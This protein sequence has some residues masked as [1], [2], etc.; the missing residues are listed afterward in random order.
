MG[1]STG[2]SVDLAAL[3]G[4]L[5][6]LRRD[7]DKALSPSTRDTAHEL[8]DTARFGGACASGEVI[9]S[10]TDV[11][12]AASIA[13]YN[14]GVHVDN[15]YAIA[16]ALG[17]AVT[18]Y[19]AVDAVA[20]ETFGAHAH[21]H[22][23]A[24]ALAGSSSAGGP[25]GL[26]PVF[27]GPLPAPKIP[28][29][30]LQPTP[31]AL[32]WKSFDTPRMWTMVAGEASAEA[33]AQMHAFRRLSDLLN[34]QHR[35]MLALRE[36]LVTAW[37]PRGAG[38]EM[39]AVW[40]KHATALASDSMCAYLT[41]K[42]MEGILQTLND[43]QI[44][45]SRLNDRWRHITTD[46]VPEGWDHA[47]EETNKKARVVMIEAEKAVADYRK[48]VAVPDRAERIIHADEGVIVDGGGRNGD[49]RQTN[50]DD[51]TTSSSA[52]GK[53]RDETQVPRKGGRVVVPSLPGTSPV[54]DSPELAGGPQPVRVSPSTPP[55]LLPIPPRVSDV[56]PGGG[57]YILPGSWSGGGRVLPMPYS[58]SAN[59]ANAY[60]RQVGPGVGSPGMFGMPGVPGAAAGARETSNRQRMATEQWEVAKGVPP[61][62]EPPKSTAEDPSEDAPT[63]EELADYE[64]WYERVSAPWRLP[65]EPEG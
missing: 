6:E 23:N 65:P 14:V 56:A 55:S 60:G 43:A 40:D 29:Q 61:V 32:R 51:G 24:G 2:I 44:K 28:I 39:L 59:S 20:G 1:V 19:A 47:A 9:A 48:G 63:D 12:Y 18:G 7:V 5:S 58:S 64:K 35:R 45:M 15:A 21:A 11:S 50:G 53:G 42:A 62:I 13:A 4:L 37:T 36:R 26:T 46:F 25:D 17:F 52:E 41:A 49:G 33:W 10:A 3:S 31:Y 34:D 54:V 27:V 38:A 8:G 16:G 30:E 22:A 57:A